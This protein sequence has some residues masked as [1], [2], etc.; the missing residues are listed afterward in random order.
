MFCQWKES[1]AQVTN[2][3]CP[4]KSKNAVYIFEEMTQWKSMQKRCKRRLWFCFKK[5]A[6]SKRVAN[7]SWS[8][9]EC[10]SSLLE[11][12]HGTQSLSCFTINLHNH[13]LQKTSTQQPNYAKMESWVTSLLKDIREKVGIGGSTSSTVIQSPV[14]AREYEGPPRSDKSCD[15]YPS[16]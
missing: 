14:S 9:H 5:C 2:I 1:I 3:L 4:V 7:T 12:D 10:W 6:G 16:R 8:L 11:H 15:Y 13:R